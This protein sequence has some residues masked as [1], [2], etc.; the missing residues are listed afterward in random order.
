M[1]PYYLLAIVGICSFMS[2]SDVTSLIHD[3]DNFIFSLFFLISLAEALS[4]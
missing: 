2:Y 4:I 3:I 1:Y